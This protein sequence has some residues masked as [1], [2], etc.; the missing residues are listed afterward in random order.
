VGNTLRGSRIDV[1]FDR[2]P[3]SSENQAD[4]RF[5]PIFQE[6]LVIALP[7]NHPLAAHAQIPKSSKKPPG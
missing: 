1:G 3:N 2:L 4:L 7:E 5:M 6:P